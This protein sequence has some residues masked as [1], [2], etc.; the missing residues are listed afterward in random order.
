[1]SKMFNISSAIYYQKNKKKPLE[2]AQE[3]YQIKKKE[4]KR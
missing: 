4:E 2:K 3:R 1:M